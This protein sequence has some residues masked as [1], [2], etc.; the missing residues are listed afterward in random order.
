M[1]TLALL[2]I[3]C[4][5][6]HPSDPVAAPTTP[7]PPPAAPLPTLAAAA[8]QPEPALPVH[9]VRFVANTLVRES[10][11]GGKL[12]IVTKGTVSQDR[13]ETW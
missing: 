1:R 11:Q 6:S 2:L 7:P 5:S 3:G 13:A 9:T 8:P 4:A 10:P 12:G